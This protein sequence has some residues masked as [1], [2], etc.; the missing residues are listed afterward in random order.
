MRLILVHPWW[1]DVHCP[2]D[3]PVYGMHTCMHTHNMGHTHSQ[4]IGHR[5]THMGQSCFLAASKNS[6]ILGLKCVL[7]TGTKVILLGCWC[8][9]IFRRKMSLNEWQGKFHNFLLIIEDSL[10][11]LKL[12]PPYPHLSQ[13]CFICNIIIKPASCWNGRL[14]IDTFTYITSNLWAHQGQWHS[15]PLV[16]EKE[17]VSGSSATCQRSLKK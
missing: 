4:S 10:Q 2:P 1:R 17:E 6:G 13:S 7:Q 16:N 3:I 11:V 12:P 5:H 8:H 15:S 9:H 14:C